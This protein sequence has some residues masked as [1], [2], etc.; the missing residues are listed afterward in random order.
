MHS[1]LALAVPAM[2][3]GIALR[4][5]ARAL[6]ATQQ[7]NPPTIGFE[8]CGYSWPMIAGGQA[9]GFDRE[10]AMTN[11][12]RDIHAVCKVASLVGGYP[13]TLRHAPQAIPP[14]GLSIPEQQSH[15]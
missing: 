1:G 5:G 7:S 9:S 6:P 10:H 11:A 14:G 13:V 15:L 4:D 12:T 2:I 3:G 8:L